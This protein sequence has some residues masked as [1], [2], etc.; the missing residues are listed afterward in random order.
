M[1]YTP[2]KNGIYAILDRLTFGV[3][4]I[5]YI[6]L[7][8][9]ILPK[10]EYGLLMLSISLFFLLN[11]L[12]DGG[13]GNA[14]IKYGAEK[15]NK[16]L[17]R[18]YTNALILKIILSCLASILILIGAP[19]ISHILREP[20][21]EP[22]L[23]ILPLLVFS[24]A[25]NSYFKQV[26]QSKQKIR[27]IFFTNLIGLISVIGLFYYF[28]SNNFLNS[29]E[30]VLYIIILS[31]VFAIPV[32]LYFSRQML[33]ISFEN[34][35]LHWVKKLLKFSKHSFSTGLAVNIY[36][37]TDTLMLSYFIGATA[38]ASYNAIWVI[39][40][41]INFIPA[42]GSM[43]LLPH[44][45]KFQRNIYT[46]KNDLK[47]A[48]K[49]TYMITIPLIVIFIIFSKDIV[50]ILYGGKYLSNHTLLWVLAMWGLLRPA[51]MYFGN[52]F[53]GIN[54]PHVSARIIWIAALINVIL[55]S[56]LIPYYNIYG[57]AIAS[58]LSILFAVI[59]F[60]VEFNRVEKKS[61]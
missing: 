22:L 47:K 17:D 33:N 59:L 4:G 55:N 16:E 57:A 6:V 58:I 29:A 21:L 52:V 35:N 51:S 14:L 5:F 54:K 36:L 23:L 61:F 11:L 40:E 48:F 12:N 50:G 20:S 13:I 26:L 44:A 39:A 43:I 7:S 41:S 15:D 46:I 28:H 49:I 34:L 31:N 56:I 25:V 45:S 9:R 38:V 18:V 42:A 32:G 60:V 19:L 30:Y 3:Y 1:T 8:A 2:F 24:S 10:V 37:R 53:L 27:E